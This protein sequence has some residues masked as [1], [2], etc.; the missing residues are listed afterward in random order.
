VTTDVPDCK[1]SAIAIEPSSPISLPCNSRLVTADVPEERAPMMALAPSGPMQLLPRLR[2][3]NTVINFRSDP[4]RMVSAGWRSWPERSAFVW[5]RVMLVSM[6]PLSAPILASIVADSMSKLF[7]SRLHFLSTDVA[8]RRY[9]MSMAA[10]TW[11]P[12]SDKS[13]S[14][15]TLS[16]RICCTGMPQTT[17]KPAQATAAIVSLNGGSPS[18]EMQLLRASLAVPRRKNPT[19]PSSSMSSSTFAARMAATSTT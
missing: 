16:S 15:V 4:I 6:M 3:V 8:G 10:A 1:A 5:S 9:A 7:L 19:S 13:S 2:S 17:P 12:L 14:A 11:S 18:P